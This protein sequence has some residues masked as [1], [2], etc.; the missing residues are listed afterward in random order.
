MKEELPEILDRNDLQRLEDKNRVIYFNYL[1][2]IPKINE[3]NLLR[4]LKGKSHALVDKHLY[5]TYGSFAYRQ[6]FVCY[7]WELCL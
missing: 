6:T 3:K 5:V 1:G 4:I 7:I 2:N